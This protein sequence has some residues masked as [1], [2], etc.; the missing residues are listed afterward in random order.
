[1]ERTR[2]VGQYALVVGAVIVLLGVGGLLLGEQSLFGLL[3]IDLAEDLIHL[4][5]GGLMVYV[6]LAHRDNALAR[7]VVGGLGVVYLLV[8]LLGFVVPD[9][10]GLLP[11]R[12]SIVDNLLHLVLGVLGIVVAWVL[13][14]AAT[15]RA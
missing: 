4:V 7:N 10:F 1:M 14:R 5:T 13:P 9:L 11:H 2:V 12:Y 15:A 6:G 8:G 3:N